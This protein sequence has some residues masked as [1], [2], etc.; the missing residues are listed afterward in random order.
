MKR[1]GGLRGNQ[2]TLNRI[3]LP[4]LGGLLVSSLGA[5]LFAAT[6]NNQDVTVKLREVSVF[7]S[8]K[9]NFLRGQMCRCQDMPFPE[10][11]HY[12]AFASKTPVFGSIRFGGRPDDTNSGVLFYFAVD[13]S[14]GTGKGYDRLYF[15]AN[16]DLDLHNDPVA[17]TQQPP[18][19]HGYKPN[20]SG[21]KSVAAFDF[22]K[23]N[24]GTNGASANPVEVMPRL[25]LT[26]DDKQTYRFMFFVRTRFFE[27]DIKVAGE[28]FH[29]LLGND[30]VI[31]PS[32]D[33]PGT[34]LVLSQGNNT[35]DWWGGDRISAIHKVKGRFFSFSASPAGNEL[36]VHPYQGN[37]G[38]FEVGPG[39][40]ALT[41][42]SAWGSFEARD[43]AVPVGG[44]IKDG[45][46]VE[47]SR[48]QVPVGDYLPEY[49]T[50]QFGRLRITLSQNYHS[51]GKRQSR[52]GRPN[53]Y[54]ITIR[55]DRPYVLDFSNQPDVMFTSPTNN[56]RVKP[57]DTLMVAAVLVDPK[58]DIMI[59]GLADTSHKQTQDA[60]GKPLGYER[61]LSLD[62][63]VIITRSNGEKV[64]EGVMPF[65]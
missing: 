45:R 32:F 7:D 3:V 35:F 6:G 60:A 1:P 22:L 42:F 65:G 19:D 21:I 63:K 8:G 28:M 55:K 13:E 59:R 14:R 47:V 64:A 9:D 39:N 38:T 16:R 25:L 56:Q 20:F 18:P 24:L 27:G 50:L 31:S 5:T 23:L 17:K 51:D 52:D 36:T 10:V 34:A 62:P 26:G 58:L 57:G 53:V 61:N 40:R 44:D 2:G 4:L 11:K 49:L 46:P 43:W 12:P 37:F 48:C 15:D 29:V 41:N 33:F 30:Y 54:G